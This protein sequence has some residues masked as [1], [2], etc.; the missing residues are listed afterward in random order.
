MKKLLLAAL[1]ILLTACAPQTAEPMPTLTPSPTSSPPSPT[2]SPPPPEPTIEPT[3]VHLNMEDID[4]MSDD[5]KLNLVVG[6]E[7]SNKFP[8]TIHANIV[9]IEDGDGY[10]AYN[11]QTGEVIDLQS[12]GIAVLETKSG[13]IVE[14]EGYTLENIREAIEADNPY[15][16]LDEYENESQKDAKVALYGWIYREFNVDME[17]YRVG[18]PVENSQTGQ[19]FWVFVL[20][21][22][23]DDGGYGSLVTYRNS[24][25]IYIVKYVYDYPESIQDGIR[26]R[27]GF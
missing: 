20:G 19:I 9:I 1:A 4:N 6:F 7:D 17:G 21:V 8:S 10:L 23:N 14:F 22:T 5:E 24:E 12:A 3:P 2:S 15:L 11:I 18:F 16:R 27:G 25:G 26:H 13:G